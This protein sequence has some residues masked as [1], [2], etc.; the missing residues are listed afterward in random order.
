MVKRVSEELAKS[1]RILYPVAEVI[2]NVLRLS[3][4]NTLATQVAIRDQTKCFG[5]KR[6]RTDNDVGSLVRQVS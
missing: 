4:D 3:H 2:V 5:L 6:F 1:T